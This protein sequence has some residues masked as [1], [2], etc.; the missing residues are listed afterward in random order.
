MDDVETLIGRIYGG[1]ER[2]SNGRLCHICTQFISKW[3]EV[4]AYVSASP[5]DL[6]SG[7]AE[8]LRL[9]SLGRDVVGALENCDLAVHGERV[10]AVLAGEGFC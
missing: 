2:F 1:R 3:E 7:E 5:N 6:L 9:V 8:C 10:V 4:R